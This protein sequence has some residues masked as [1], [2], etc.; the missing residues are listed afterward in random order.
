MD[1]FQV[2]YAA[3]KIDDDTTLITSAEDIEAKSA[4]IIAAALNDYPTNGQ[5]SVHLTDNTSS[6]TLTIDY[7]DTL[8]N[9]LNSS[10]DNVLTANALILQRIL[11]DGL[12]GGA[13]E[14]VVS[15]INTNYKL[16]WGGHGDDEDFDE[17]SLQP[18][19]QAIAQFNEMVDLRSIIRP[20]IA[21]TYAEGSYP[22]Y[23]RLG[24]NVKPVIDHYPLTVC[25]PSDY[26]YQG[27][28]VL[29]FNVNNLKSRLQ[30]TYKKNKKR[31][32]IYFEDVK[33][34]I[35]ANY[36]GEVYKAYTDGE[37]YVRLDPRYTGCVKY[38]DMGRKFGVSPLFKCLKPL[39][40]L[41]N[42]E[43]ADVSDSKARSKK[44][45]HQLLRK[46]LMGPDGT[47]KGLGEVAH[48]HQQA[49]QALKTSFC[50]YTSAPWVESLSYVQA[51]TN[52][53]DSINQQ[54][55]YTQ[56]LLAALGIG[57]TD[58]GASVGAGNIS[59][60]Q[61][62]KKINAISED[63]EDVI[64]HFYQTYLEDNG[65]DPRL[66]PKIRIIDAEELEFSLRKELASFLYSTL[67]LSMSTALDVLGFDAEEE[68]AKRQRE[69]DD[70]YDGVFYARKEDASAE[71]NPVGRPAGKT[72]DDKQEY[73]KVYNKTERR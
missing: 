66:A 57:F 11:S 50:L 29:E 25:Y 7:I 71:A 24:K 72:A 62:L 17:E 1:N 64:Y 26:R 19:K 65:L 3:S 53:E 73:D 34:E 37:Q 40:V 69:N 14:A 46:E 67:N 55:L 5:S 23:L 45:I 36:P 47:R 6:Q 41:E 21:G 42:I 31:K 12:F 8:A 10:L 4:Q 44:I 39:I 27:K 33:K 49:A 56:K 43:T 35:Q 63:L 28:Y 48:A 13:Y 68:R 20:A 30:K 18:V 60:Q 51:K 52:N 16:I 58:L 61:L 54:K 2:E 38:N 32:A 70:G 59:I 22:M 9:G 15:N